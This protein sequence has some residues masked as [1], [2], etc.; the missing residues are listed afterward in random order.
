MMNM[1]DLSAPANSIAL[2]DDPCHLRAAATQSASTRA[3]DARFLLASP[4][5]PQ[6]RIR[7]R[8]QYGKQPRSRPRRLS[9]PLLPILQR[10]DTHA[11]EL[12]KDPLGETHRVAHS[13]HP[14]R[15]KDACATEPPSG[16]LRCHEVIIPL[17]ARGV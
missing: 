2:P 15:P 10:L 5:R 7:V 3:R 16:L 1:R 8:Q 4:P 17:S 14:R 13:D 6:P 11:D 12:G 9:P